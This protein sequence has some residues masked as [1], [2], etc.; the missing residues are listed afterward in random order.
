MITLKQPTVCHKDDKNRYRCYNYFG[1]RR[2]PA[3]YN[4]FNNDRYYRITY[5]KVNTLL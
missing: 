4:Q 1:L 5:L 2:Y 3:N